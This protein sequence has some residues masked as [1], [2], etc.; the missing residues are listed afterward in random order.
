VFDVLLLR[1]SWQPGTSLALALLEDQMQ[2]KARFG[3]GDVKDF[4][5]TMNR[6]W[7]SGQ[8]TMAFHNTSSLVYRARMAFAPA[9]PLL[10]RLRSSTRLAAFV[11]LV[12]A[13]KIGLIAACAKHEVAELGLGGGDTAGW[14]LEAATADGADGADD[15]SGGVPGH[16]GACNHCQCHHAPALLLESHLVAWVPPTGT[17]FDLAGSLPNTSASLELRPPIA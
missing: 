10:A 15:P 7:H 4:S 8:L 17:A 16:A 9:R 11:L 6:A 2:S 1:I 5:A 3:F 14:V 12:F 13:L